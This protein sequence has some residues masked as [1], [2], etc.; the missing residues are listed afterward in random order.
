MKLREFEGE[1]VKIKLKDGTKHEGIVTDFVFAEDN[2][3]KKIV[4]L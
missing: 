2:N 4:S 1:F 3:P